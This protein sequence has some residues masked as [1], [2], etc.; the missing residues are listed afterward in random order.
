MENNNFENMEALETGNEEN[1]GIFDK[2]KTL[3][4]KIIIPVVAVVLAV[5]LAVSILPSVL[6]NTYKTPINSMVQILNSKKYISPIDQNLKML[7]G[8]AKS[9]YKEIY[10]LLK[11]SEN[12]IDAMEE[13]EEEFLDQIEE[14]KEEYGSNYKVSYKITDKVALEKDD[15]KDFRDDLRG[16]AD[17]IK[18]EILDETDEY[19]SD[20]WED[21]AD[22]LDISKENAK[23]VV[24]SLEKIQKKYKNAK[25]SAGYKIEAD[26]LISGSELDEPEEED[27][28]FY[29]YKVDGRW[30]IG[31]NII[32]VFS[33]I[34]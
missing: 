2:I 23:K 20:D 27:V 33:Q 1:S 28:T 29:I 19:D 14:N 16:F 31:D 3:P 7:N 21:M 8:F 18:D 17:E 13:A 4:L 24:K 12:Y 10:N 34:F 11:K 25:V 30:V 9:E 22:E 15:L 6:G 26:I 32:D 5:V